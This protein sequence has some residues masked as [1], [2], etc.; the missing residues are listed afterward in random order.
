[1]K[2]SVITV[3]YNCEEAIKETLESVKKQKGADFEYVVIDGA[4]SDST[5]EIARQYQDKIPNMR[6]FSEPD[7]G[8]YDAMNKGV[9]KAEGAYVFFLNAGD[10]FESEN[11]LAKVEDYLGSKKDIFYGNVRKGDQIE[12]YP[13]VLG[14]GYLVYREKMVCHQAIFASRKILLWMPFDTTLKICADRDWLLKAIASGA[15]LQYM[16][17]LVVCSYAPGGVSGSY[18]NYNKESL[19]LAEKYGKKPAVL[20]VKIKRLIGKA[21]GH[22]W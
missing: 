17:D 20:F 22:K 6:I 14:K 12:T 3:C 21:V 10:V 2:I 16:K 5:V 15:S 4:S 8:I 7:H 18:K 19:F 13:E 1:M 11:V 9:K